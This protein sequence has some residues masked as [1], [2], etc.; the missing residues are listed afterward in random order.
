MARLPSSFWGPPPQWALIP[1]VAVGV[2]LGAL[3]F[4]LPEE[5]DG[6]VAVT[7]LKPLEAAV[8]DRAVG[9][10]LPAAEGAAGMPMEVRYG[11]PSPRTARL[12]SE[13]RPG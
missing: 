10:G 7:A 11:V 13:P 8:D 2:V 1:L 5:G 3:A 9:S 4:R 6:P 12:W